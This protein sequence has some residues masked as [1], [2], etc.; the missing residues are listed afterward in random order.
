[1]HGEKYEIEAPVMSAH[2]L[3]IGTPYIDLGGSSKIRLL[4]DPE[5]EVNLRF[6]KK[7]WLSKEEYKVEGE[8]IRTKKAG[9]KE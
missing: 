2:N 5:L 6:T 7:G 1:M 4:Q 3:I 8:V 9:K